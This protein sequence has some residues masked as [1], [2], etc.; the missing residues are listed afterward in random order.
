V[1]RPVKR[2][3]V[4]HAAVAAELRAKPGVW[5]PVAEYPARTSADGTAHRI[6]TGYEAPM[7][8]PAGAFEARVELTEL[9]ARVE[10]RYVG[11]SS[12]QRT[13]TPRP[14]EKPAVHI[15]PMRDCERV[16]G[17]IARGEVLAG[18][19]GA[20][21]IA[22]KHEAAYGDVW[23]RNTAWADALAELTSGGG[24]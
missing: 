19:E 16:L 24:A 1:S 9:G 11:D 3:H 13:T 10:A 18:A 21:A 12:L 8:R 6:R 22:A 15:Q 2:R 4:R 14:A 23:T 5:A 7:Y 20:R 17:Q